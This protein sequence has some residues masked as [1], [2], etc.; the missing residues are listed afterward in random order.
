MML[1]GCRDPQRSDNIST[2]KGIRL[3]TRNSALG[4]ERVHSFAEFTLVPAFSTVPAMMATGRLLHYKKG[5]RGSRAIARHLRRCR[6]QGRPAAPPGPGGSCV[7]R[8]RL[9]AASP[10]VG[11]A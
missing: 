1:N 9:L 7:A 6:R 2:T 8:V 3:G 11:R 10:S 5:V 4:S